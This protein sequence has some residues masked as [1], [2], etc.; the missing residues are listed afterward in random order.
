LIG[1]D[2]AQNLKAEAISNLKRKL[3]QERQQH[4]EQMAVWQRRLDDAEQ[5]GLLRKE[6]YNAWMQAEQQ[7]AALR[8]SQTEVGWAGG[9]EV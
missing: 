4:Q 9:K 1:V 5:Q 3:H 7:S 2:L 8:L 6:E